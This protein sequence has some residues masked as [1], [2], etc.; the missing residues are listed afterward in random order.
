MLRRSALAAAPTVPLLLI[1]LSCGR[2]EGSPTS[3]PASTSTPFVTPTRIVTA[4]PEAID[5]VDVVPLQFGKEAE[6]PVDVA[7][8]VETGCI[9][10]DG[11][12]TGLVRLYRDPSEQVRTD[13]LFSPEAAHLPPRLVSDPK[14]EP[15]GTR[16]EEPYIT[17]FALGHDATEIVVGVCSR[18]YCGGLGLA[19]SDAETTLFRS[20][21][22]GLTWAQYGILDGGYY[23]VAITKDGVLLNH[24]LES[25][26]AQQAAP[27]YQFFPSGALLQPPP[28]ASEGWPM[29][30]PSGELIWRSKDGRLLRSD[31]S[32]FLALR[33]AAAFG[34]AGTSTG[35]KPDPSGERL[36]VALSR[37]GPGQASEQTYFG[38][39]SLGGDLTEVFSSPEYTT[40][41]GWINSAMLAGNT[42]ISPEQL[43]TPVPDPF[44]NYLPALFDLGEREVHP[45]PQP[46]LDP[47]F[48]NGRNQIQAV[49]QGPFAR[50]VNTES[51]LNVR[52]GP[53]MVA[54]VLACA[55]DGVLLRDTGETR[56]VDGATWARVVT[57]AGVEGWANSQFLER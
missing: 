28:E 13:P 10:C 3:T 45:I 43:K 39:A 30:Y 21:D 48:R 36:A 15:T 57:P 47:P 24:Q 49:L 34:I 56:E 25:E 50:V 37:H 51:C 41:G 11:P 18:G 32:E 26:P 4:T 1:V 35:V 29:S 53:G 2:G 19:T 6:I 16:E 46:F 42:G 20:L 12:T 7:L 44:V 31:G 52:A 33:Q 23:V 17:G 5:G 40:I 8:I 54:A 14:A 27:A 9:Q 22:G 38:I 55:A